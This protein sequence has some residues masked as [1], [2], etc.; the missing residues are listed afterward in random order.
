VFY[1]IHHQITYR[2]DQPV[3]LA[4]HFLRLRPRCDVT[5][6]LRQFT[7]EIDPAPEQ[8]YETLDLDG[9]AV[10]KARFTAKGT[11]QL[12]I[13]A[14]S[15]VETFRTNPFDYLLEPW[16]TTLPLDYPALLNHQLQPY[17]GGQFAG[18]FGAIDPT[19]SQLAQ[20][21]WL[22]TSGNLVGFLSALNQM[23]YQNCGYRLRE[24]G[25]PY[26]PS[27]TWA[28]KSGSCR[29]YTVLFME[30]CR[31]AG[32]ASRFVSGYQEGDPDSN[33]RHLHAWAEVYLPGAGWRGYDPTHGLAVAAGHIALVA[34]PTAVNSAPVTGTLKT[35][36]A[37]SEMSYELKIQ[38]LEAHL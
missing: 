35:T 8:L 30:V 18:G 11:T 15:E 12:V 29:D 19:A 16:A 10:L 7:L 20:Q 23:I 3:L 17:L 33:D 14:I 13:T 36:G 37:Q 32:L 28:Q 2:Y 22:E 31:A 26:P 21:L 24:T 25:S 5:Q 4:P 9:N 1:R 38:I 27:I 6:T 34:T